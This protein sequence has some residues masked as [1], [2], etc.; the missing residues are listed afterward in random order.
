[1]IPW[2]YAVAALGFGLQLGSFL[3][4]RRQAKEQQREF[5]RRMDALREQTKAHEREAAK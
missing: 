1:M 4:E 2:Y 3:E 5:D